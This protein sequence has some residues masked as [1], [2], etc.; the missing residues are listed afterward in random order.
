M[1]KKKKYD[2]RKVLAKEFRIVDNGMQISYNRSAKQITNGSHGSASQLSVV[3]FVY[4]MWNLCVIIWMLAVDDTVSQ[5]HTRRENNHRMIW[6]NM[7]W[8]TYVASVYRCPNDCLVAKHPI[9]RIHE[10]K[11]LSTAKSEIWPILR[12]FLCSFHSFLFHSLERD[13]D[14]VAK[15]QFSR[16]CYLE[17]ELIED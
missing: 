16:M 14:S 17:C 12:W 10:N 5:S 13:D 4:F 1:K 8:D 6:I 9:S 3:V 11:R 2:W 15:K 7:T